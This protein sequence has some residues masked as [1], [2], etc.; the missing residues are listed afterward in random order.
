M[1]RTEIRPG[2]YDA[3]IKPSVFIEVKAAASS[4]PLFELRN[5]LHAHAQVKEAFERQYPFKDRDIQN[6]AEHECQHGLLAVLKH[7]VRLR[8]ISVEPGP[9][10]L[11][12]TEFDGHVNLSDFAEISAASLTDTVAGGRAS[13]TGG[14]L[15]SIYSLQSAGYV[16]ISTETLKDNAQEF[17]GNFP[18][19]FRKKLGLI[20]S[21]EGS[22]NHE[23]FLKAIEKARQW[24]EAESEVHKISFE[25][26]SM[27]EKEYKKSEEFTRFIYEPEK[28]VVEYIGGAKNGEK[29]DICNRCGGHNMHKPNCMM[30]KKDTIELQKHHNASNINEAKMLI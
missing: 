5:K 28:V 19:G 7:G 20:L 14:D 22:L 17:L 15:F 27:D 4:D 26:P 2:I 3:G 25:I 23:G 24:E 18:K 29:I 21:K 6:T 1:S 16:N 12:I 11:G 10:Y 8:R 9:G 30:N 13:G